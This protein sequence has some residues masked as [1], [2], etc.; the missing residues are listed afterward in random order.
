MARS[1]LTEEFMIELETVTVEHPDTPGATMII[2]KTDFDPAIHKLYEP[3][4]E[5]AKPKV[6]PAKT[7]KPEPEK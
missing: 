7:P 4:S 2:N 5:D 3:E 1:L 6:K